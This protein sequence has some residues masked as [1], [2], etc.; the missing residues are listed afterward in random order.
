MDSHHKLIRWRFV[1]HAA[2]DG[3]SRTLL[4]V[5]CTDNNKA[6]MVL[7][8]FLD[9]VSKYGL[10]QRVH[11]D[12]GGENI[13]VWKYVIAA[14]GGDASCIL[15]G[16]LTHNE[17]I[18]H[19][20]RDVHRSVTSTYAEVF[21]CL[22]SDSLL[23]PLNEVDLYCL[24]FIYLPRI[25]KSLTE[26]HNSWNCHSLSTEGSKTPHQLFFEGIIASE[27]DESCVQTLT[28]TAQIEIESSNP[29]V[30]PS[31]T[32]QPCPELQLQLQCIYPLATSTENGKDIYFTAIHIVGDHLQKSCTLCNGGNN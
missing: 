19:L 31:N 15:T 26:F 10:P 11:S 24:H 28:S 27:N 7:S 3:F 6:N 4:Y 18:E 5:V 29:V 25:G 1:T 21:R 20:W 12:H 23:D 22:E 2:V 8:C 13:E 32:F 16:S 9:G 17:R 14:R 30:V